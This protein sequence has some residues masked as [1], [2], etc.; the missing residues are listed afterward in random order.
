MRTLLLDNFDSYTYNLFQLIAQVQGV[1]PTVLRNDAPEGADV[2]LHEFDNI[3]ISP[4]PGH[5]GNSR[6]FGFSQRILAEATIPVLGVCLGHQGIGLAESAEVGPTAVPRHGHLTTVRHDGRDLFD[7]IPQG[8]T[9]VRYHS[10]AIR[11]PLPPTLEATAWSED[12]V[13]MGI[14][15]R[16]RPQW[17]VQFHPESIL[18]EHG[19]R[20]FGNF[21]DLTREHGSARRRVMTGWTP[22]THEPALPIA[23]PVTQPLSIIRLVDEPATQPLPLA[24]LAAQ[25]VEY[26]L[27]KRVIDFAVDAEQ[28]F[29]R[30]FAREPRAFWLD[31]S[32]VEAG[33]ARFSYFGD[34]TGPLAEYVRYDVPT[35]VVHVERPGQP[36]KSLVGNVFDYLKTA[37]AGRRVDDDSLPFDFTCGY[38]GYLGYEAKSDCGKSNAHQ[39]TTP[40]ACWLFADRMVVV[41]HQKGTTYLLSLSDDT[42]ASQDSSDQWLDQTAAFLRLQGPVEP[43]QPVDPEVAAATLA[44]STG[45][46]RS[47]EPWLVRDREQYLADIDAC[48]RQLIAGE[49]YEVCMTNAAWLPAL[50]DPLEYHRL[51]REFNP[52]PYAAYLQFGDVAV[53][54]SSPERFLKIGRDGTVE[55]K[56]IKGTVARDARPEE[57]ARLRASLVKSAKTRAENLMI[58]DLLRND[59]GQVCEVGTV[60]VPKLMATETYATVHQLVSTV[61]GHLRPSVDSVDCVRACF[62]AGSMTGAPKLR[63]LDIIDTLETEARGVYSGAIGFFSCNGTADL[64]VVIRTAVFVDG[65]MHLGAGGAIV[66]DS[67]PEEEYAEMLLK[68]AA[69]MRAYWAWI[70]ANN[71]TGRADTDP[72]DRFASQLPLQGL[73]VRK[74]ALPYGRPV[75]AKALA[76]PGEVN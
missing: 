32:R 56:P 24:E 14:R 15:H 64:N 10:L 3:V 12:G 6:D 16:T 40:D 67:D 38:V 45:S 52:A 69:P 72:Q 44:A 26:R 29:V 35:G 68:M 66:L 62:P 4:G 7:W 70:S 31:S 1:E 61:Q 21:R 63:T 55:A 17:G 71:P 59:L 36:A 73:A 49:S 43:E 8:F 37:L 9:A 47:V 51:L 11:Q 27:Q 30:R 42:A 33:Q 58:V 34:G 48:K 53:A 57:D 50:A 28:A 75:R 22:A 76:H 65:R 25:P 39:A 13:L 19:H 60:R 41:D 20:L 18:T 5:P 54:S 74:A 2:D 46:D 23:S